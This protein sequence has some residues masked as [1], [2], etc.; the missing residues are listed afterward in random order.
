MNLSTV[1]L[2]DAGL[3]KLEVIKV[4]RVIGGLG[5]KAAHD[6][7]KQ[8]PKPVI[9]NVTRDSAL[10]IAKWFTQAGTTVDSI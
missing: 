8:P 10:A 3:R 2:K 9:T 4:V 6:L 5:L 1:V 7:V